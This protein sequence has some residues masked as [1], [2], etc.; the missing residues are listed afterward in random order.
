M[1]RLQI[2]MP[3]YYL[4]TTYLIDNTKLF[5]IIVKENSSFINKQTIIKCYYMVFKILKF[6]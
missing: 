6:T 5:I 3:N 4:T 2:K 1:F